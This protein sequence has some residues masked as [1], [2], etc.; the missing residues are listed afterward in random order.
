[1]RTVLFFLSPLHLF[2]FS[3]RVW[4]VCQHWGLFP[5]EKVRTALDFSSS[6]SF[7]QAIP[8]YE[9]RRPLFPARSCSKGLCSFKLSRQISVRKFFF[10]GCPVQFSGPTSFLPLGIYSLCGP[11]PYSAAFFFP[12]TVGRAGPGP[13]RV[14][15]ARLLVSFFFAFPRNGLNMSGAFSPP[16]LVLFFFPPPF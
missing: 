8:P 15:C 7:L 1:M 4:R 9:F 10:S 11:S 6:S 16:F 3:G 5:L 13:G 12:L 14:F 2:D